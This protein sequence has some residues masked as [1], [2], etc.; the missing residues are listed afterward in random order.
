MV[1]GDG[2]VAIAAPQRLRT[3][4]SLA[5]LSY[6]VCMRKITLL[7]VHCTAT[8]AGKPFDVA[9]IRAMHLARGWSDIGY[10]KLIGIGGEVWDGR[11]EH[12]AGAHIKGHNSESLAVCYV[13]GISADG[14]PADTRTPDQCQAMEHVL[15]RWRAQF[16]AAAIRGHR[17][18]SPDRNHD[19]RITRDEWLK[20]CPCFDVRAWCCSVGIDPQ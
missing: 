11:P 7:A 16:P 10:H 4:K 15:R 19:G 1:D 8:L 9:A 14:H 20:D 13:G 2:R 6:S 12:I 18:M 5:G 17:D 3:P